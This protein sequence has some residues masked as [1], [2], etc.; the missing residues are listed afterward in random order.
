MEKFYQVELE[1]LANHVK[2]PNELGKNPNL[3]SPHKRN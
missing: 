1:K 2:E 3:G